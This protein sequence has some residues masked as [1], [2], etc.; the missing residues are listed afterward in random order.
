MKTGEVVWSNQNPI[1]QWNFPDICSNIYKNYDQ[2]QTISAITFSFNN[3][4]IKN[5]SYCVRVIAWTSVWIKYTP[6]VLLYSTYTRIIIHCNALRFTVKCNFVFAPINDKY[7]F[8][9]QLG[10][11]KFGFSTRKLQTRINRPY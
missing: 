2:N 8:I 4:T 6:G 10:N 1:Q 3:I 9:R 7:N 11:Y 5:K